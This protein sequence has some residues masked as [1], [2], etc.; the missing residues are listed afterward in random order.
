[1]RTPFAVASTPPVTSRHLPLLPALTKYVA[2][3]PAGVKY[4]CWLVWSAPRHPNC[5]TATPLP[6]AA[7]PPV[8]SRHLLLCAAR[9]MYGPPTSALAATSHAA[10]VSA[11]ATT[12]TAT[13]L[14]IVIARAGY[15][16][17]T[18]RVKARLAQRP[19]RLLRPASAGGSHPL[20]GARTSRLQSDGSRRARTP[21]RGRGADEP[22]GGAC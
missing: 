15:V 4:H 6:V 8:T 14:Q 2:P 21:R 3:S 10:S 11:A 18:S 20:P 22:T 16:S 5:W 17:R 12:K 1:M 19:L 13:R 7:G 9:S